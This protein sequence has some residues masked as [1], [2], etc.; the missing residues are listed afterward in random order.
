MEERERVRENERERGGRE[1]GKKRYRGMGEER[2]KR[3]RIGMEDRKK[4]QLPYLTHH[5][6]CL[7]EGGIAE[8]SAL[9]AAI[10]AV[11]DAIAQTG[12]VSHA[13]NA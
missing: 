8:V 2:D 4:A 5:S 11:R 3:N 6:L 10:E 7:A 12:V 1:G 9:V 13:A